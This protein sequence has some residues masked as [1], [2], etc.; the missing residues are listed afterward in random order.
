MIDWL[1]P[2]HP[3]AASL[4]RNAILL[5]K[6]SGSVDDLLAAVIR[7]RAIVNAAVIGS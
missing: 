6:W 1:F 3:G 4:T 2:L 5:T 7:V